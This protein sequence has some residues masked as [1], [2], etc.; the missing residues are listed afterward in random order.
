M[1]AGGRGYT[2]PPSL[3][4][5][6]STAPFLL[7]N[8][9]GR[10]EIEPVGRGADAR[11]STTRSA[12]C[13]GRSAATRTRCSATRFPAS[14]TASATARRPATAASRPTSPCRAGYLPEFLQADAQRAAGAVPGALHRRRRP[15]RT[16]SA[17]ARRSACSPTCNLLSEDR[18]PQQVAHAGRAVERAAWSGLLERLHK[19]GGNAHRASR[20]GRHSRPGRPAARAE[21]VSGP[22]RQ[23]R[24]PVRHQA[25]GRGQARADRVPEDVL[26]G[27]AD[28]AARHL[29]HQPLGA[30]RQHR[31]GA[32]GLDQQHLDGAGPRRTAGS[33]RSSG[34]CSTRC[35]ATRWPGW[36]RR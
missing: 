14:S 3:V 20:R 19:L 15:A 17:R 21:Q 18:D 31:V 28:H 32:A 8:T 35:S 7:N 26:T 10:F 1:P 9:V 30:A 16:D 24:P 6:W 2:R 13:S 29:E 23:P 34:R 27:E 12:R 5:L 25:A 11:R 22:G 36:S 33:I 4:S